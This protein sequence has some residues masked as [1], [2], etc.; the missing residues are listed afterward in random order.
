MEKDEKKIDAKSSHDKKEKLVGVQDGPRGGSLDSGGGASSR[1][2]LVGRTTTQPYLRV[3]SID[4]YVRTLGSKP[5]LGSVGSRTKSQLNLQ[6]LSKKCD[7]ILGLDCRRPALHRIH[8][9][10]FDLS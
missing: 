6:V 7:S 10:H 4:D 9:C 3:G 8:S 5:D 2:S 1:P